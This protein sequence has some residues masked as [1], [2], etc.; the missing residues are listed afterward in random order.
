MK[1]Y[2]LSLF[3]ACITIVNF[4]AD[5][6]QSPY[7]TKAERE[8]EKLKILNHKIAFGFH[9]G[10]FELF[11]FAKVDDITS[12]ININDYHNMY[13]LEVEYYLY[14]SVAAQISVG[15]ILIPQQQNIDSII[16][17]PGSGLGG[18]QAKGSGKGGAVLPVTFGIKKTFLDGLIRPYVS[19]LSGLT[20]IKIGKGTGSGSI[21]GIEKDIDY[22]SKL[23]FNYQIGTG[24]QYRL[25]KVVRFD[26]GLNYYG[27]PTFT[28]PIGGINAYQGLYVFVGL[29]FIL[30]P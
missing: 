4:K 27:S 23:V 29:N 14:E 30:N 28:P 19:L 2:F 24:I 22:E 13:N 12:N 8:Y 18:I 15:L 9:Y 7:K 1:L 26:F 20:I 17:T 21:N 3:I 16:I 6:Q 5:A 11:P 10:Y 25:G